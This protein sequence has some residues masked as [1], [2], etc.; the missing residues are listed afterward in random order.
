MCPGGGDIF[1]AEWVL[2][3]AGPDQWDDGYHAVIGIARVH[4]GLRGNPRYHEKQNGREA[5]ESNHRATLSIVF[6]TCLK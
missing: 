2:G 1:P 5:A 4:A 6:K 3:R